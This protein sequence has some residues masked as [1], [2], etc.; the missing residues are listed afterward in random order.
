MTNIFDPFSILDHVQTREG[1]CRPRGRRMDRG[2]NQTGRRTWQGR[3]GEG[4][5]GGVGWRLKESRPCVIPEQL[6]VPHIAAQSVH[7]LM[8]AHVHHLENRRTPSGGAGQEP[9]SQ[10][11][12]GE[13]RRIE[14]DAGGMGLDDL[15]HAAIGQP[16]LL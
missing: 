15:G 8:T 3:R 14:P 7:A 10:R 4:Y 11:V 2:G 12:P 6:G 1:R 5:G 9:R 13:T 16:G